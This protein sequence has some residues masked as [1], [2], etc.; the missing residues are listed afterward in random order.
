MNGVDIVLGLI[1]LYALYRGFRS[2]LVVELCGILGLLIGAYLAYRFSG[3]L[4][5]ALDLR[6]AFGQEVSFVLILVGALVLIALAGRLVSRVIDYAGLG[7][8]NKLLGAIA[9]VLKVAL[10]VGLLLTAFDAVNRTTRWADTETLDRLVLYK[11]VRDLAGLIFPYIG[12]DAVQDF[13][14]QRIE[15]TPRETAPDDRPWQEREAPDTVPSPAGA[16]EHI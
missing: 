4:A 12:F 7:V 14:R 8:V 13:Y 1:L 3:D 6:I 9:S 5:R 10:V 2:G 11:P 15:G 16:W